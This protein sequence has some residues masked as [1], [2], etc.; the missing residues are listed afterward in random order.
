MDSSMFLTASI[1][2]SDSEGGKN[3]ARKGSSYSFTSTP[4][5]TPKKE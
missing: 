4:T 2:L 1:A 3:P 5:N